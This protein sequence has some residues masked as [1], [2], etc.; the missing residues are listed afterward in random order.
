MLRF[1]FSL[2]TQSGQVVEN[3]LIAGTDQPDAERKLRQMY[4]HCQVTRCEI[5]QEEMKLGQAASVEG[6]L[7]LIGRSSEQTK[8]LMH[9][10]QPGWLVPIQQEGVAF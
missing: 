6:I 2:Q 9:A 10:S 5:K 4:C 1:Y 3:I 8:L 7:S